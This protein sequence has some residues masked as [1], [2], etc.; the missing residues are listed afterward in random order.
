[1]TPPFHFLASALSDVGCV[2][3]SNED[4]VRLVHVHDEGVLA[5]RGLLLL[6]ADGMGGHLAGEVASQVAVDTVHNTY[7][8]IAG[9]PGDAL[10]RSFEAAN[11]AVYALAEHD[12]RFS[13]MGT[14][15][16]A[17]VLCGDQAFSANVGDSRIYLV[18][19]GGIYRMTSDDSAVGELVSQGLISAADAKHHA[20]KNVILRAIGTAPAVTVSTWDKPFPIRDGDRFL[21]C[22]DGLHDLVDD[23]EIRDAV[24]L[25]APAESCGH[26]VAL[27]RERGGHDNITVAVVHVIASEASQISAKITR[28]IRALA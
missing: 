9:S 1:M 16:T 23:E 6:V 12:A 14:T 26:L 27:A 22:S 2:R 19:D 3:T 20:E 8:E 17:L 15:G 5:E 25:E 7:Y 11:H 21:L 18:R 4:Q 28:E 24:A 10:V 13:G